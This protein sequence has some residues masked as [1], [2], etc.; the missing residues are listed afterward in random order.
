M[1]N[2]R[3]SNVYGA[4]HAVIID[5][6]EQRIY[7]LEFLG[8]EPPSFRSN[9]VVYSLRAYSG[10]GNEVIAVFALIFSDIPVLGTYHLSPQDTANVIG[11]SF[12]AE[13]QGDSPRAAWSHQ[14]EAEVVFR[15]ERQEGRAMIGTMTGR[16]VFRQGGGG[17][18]IR[19]CRVI[20]AAM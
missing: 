4:A 10:E 19:E 7:E 1:F 6:R 18:Q 15:L 12:G 2:R 16:L 11:F 5:E 9:R 8:V 3:R 13:L 20:L 17:F 14:G